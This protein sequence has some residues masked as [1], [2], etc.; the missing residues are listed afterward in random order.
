MIKTLGLTL[1]AAGMM[2]IT[3]Q[4]VPITGGISFFGA[5]TPQD[6]AAATTPDLADAT[7]IAFGGTVVGIGGTSGSFSVIPDLNSV[8]M[9]TPLVFVPPT[10]PGASLWTT[11]A[12][13]HTFSFDLTTLVVGAVSGTF[14]GAQSIT[15]SGNGDV[16]YA[17][18][19]GY[20][21]TAGTW[22]GTFNAAG[23][24]FSW[25]SSTGANV[26]DGGSTL[27]L[28]GSSIVGLFGIARKSL[29]IA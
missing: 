2:T 22:T 8:T 16:S 25:S 7:Q 27:I 14:P 13:G 3:A 10:L 23:G 21:K 24:T 1:A 6:S 5:Y 28:L 12:G 26:P 4:A 15:M 9:F 11:T 18:P 19:S 20:E 29:R 17:G